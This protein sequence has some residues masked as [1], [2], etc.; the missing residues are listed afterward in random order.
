MTSSTEDSCKAAGRGG[1]LAGVLVVVL[2]AGCG[3]DEALSPD[4][5]VDAA[6]DPCVTLALDDR[7]FQFNVFN[8]LTGLSYSVAPGVAGEAPERLL[9]ELYDSTTGGLPPLAAGTFPLG[10]PPN[11]DLATCQHCVWVPVDWN[12]FD[13]IATVLFATEGEVTLTAVE[14]PL[15]VV[16]TGSVSDVVLREAM[17]EEGQVVLVPGGACARIERLDFDTSPTPGA[18]CL[19]AED[20]GN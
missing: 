6:P 20:C 19:S 18:R 14:D 7:S 17:L 9:V 16:F 2:A 5:G 4:G 15:T 8:Q 11:A 1:R 10:A 12:G 3:G 13:P